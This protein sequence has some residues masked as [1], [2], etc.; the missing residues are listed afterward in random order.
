MKDPKVMTMLYGRSGDGGVAKDIRDETNRI[1]HNYLGEMSNNEIEEL[2]QEIGDCDDFPEFVID[3]EEWI[4]N[5]LE[6]RD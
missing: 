5:Y 2:I 6:E 3:W 1:L 4:S